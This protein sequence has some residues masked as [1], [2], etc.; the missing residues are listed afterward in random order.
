V[1]LSTRKLLAHAAVRVGGVDNLAAR[2]GISSRVV[3][4]YLTGKE[5]IP[6]LLFLVLV[7]LSLEA[8]P[9]EEPNLP[10]SQSLQDSK[11]DP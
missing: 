3:S 5:N 9:Q 2:L 10:A 1:E 6:E 11:L 8:L 4:R 7:D